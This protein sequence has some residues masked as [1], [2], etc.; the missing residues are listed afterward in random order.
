MYWFLKEI[1]TYVLKK[2]KNTFNL[3]FWPESEK[4][5]K[6]CL[7]LYNNKIK[8]KEQVNLMSLHIIF[9]LVRA[10]NILILSSDVTF[11]CVSA[12]LQA[13]S[14]MFGSSFY[15]NNDKM[16]V[17]FTCHLLRWNYVQKFHVYSKY[18]EIFVFCFSFWFISSLAI[19]IWKLS[20][21][22]LLLLMS[23]QL[24][25]LMANSQAFSDR[26]HLKRSHKKKLPLA[27][28][29]SVVQFEL[30]HVNLSFHRTIT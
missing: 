9:K 3:Q 25:R 29:M 16:S 1:N 30:S 11:V 14:L 23:L 22:A 5:H 12:S 10:K 15:Q 4:C 18:I 13:Q 26:S 27:T 17:P 21:L 20:H 6:L 2:K 8:C 24:S 28:R 7:T 19:V